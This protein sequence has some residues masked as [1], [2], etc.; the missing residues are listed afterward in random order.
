MKLLKFIISVL[1]FH[2]F[3]YC[4]INKRLPSKPN[5]NVNDV[6]TMAIKQLKPHNCVIW[7]KSF[8]ESDSITKYYNH[9]FE[10][11]WKSVVNQVPTIIIDS[12]NQPFFLTLAREDFKEKI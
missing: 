12:D 11:I 9:E 2:T 3:C 5:K 1:S 10:A 7:K 8:F 6:V 4:A